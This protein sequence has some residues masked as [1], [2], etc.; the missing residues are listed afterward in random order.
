MGDDDVVVDEEI[1]IIVRSNA[2]KKISPV[3]LIDGLYWIVF[4]S[5]IPI[6]IVCLS[7]YLPILTWQ[8]LGNE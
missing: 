2:I 8:I 6:V 7:V 5:F 4:L 3:E 1:I